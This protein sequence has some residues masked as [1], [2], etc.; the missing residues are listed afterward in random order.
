MARLREAVGPSVAEIKSNETA[1]LAKLSP[2][3]TWRVGS[4]E[5]V[6][7]AS[8]ELLY[9]KLATGKHLVRHSLEITL[10]LHLTRCSSFPSHFTRWMATLLRWPPSSR[11]TS[12]SSVQ[13][14]RWPCKR[15]ACHSCDCRRS[16]RRCTNMKLAPP[17]SAPAFTAG[18]GATP[19]PGGTDCSLFCKCSRRGKRGQYRDISII[20]SPLAVL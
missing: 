2:T 8:G 12:C 16:N 3:G 6:D 4:F 17:R 19:R 20:V 14:G 5:V 18:P 15:R 11:H 9:S 13:A 7:V 1:F 10:P